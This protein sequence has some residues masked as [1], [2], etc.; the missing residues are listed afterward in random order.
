MP[1]FEVLKV[2]AGI[3]DSE[4]EMD[5]GVLTEHTQLLHL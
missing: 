3:K 1:K 5:Y 4:C 2:M